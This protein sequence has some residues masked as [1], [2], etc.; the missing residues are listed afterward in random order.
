MPTIT[1]PE[2]CQEILEAL[3]TEVQE[4][5]QVIVH[6]C[7]P[8]TYHI[9]SLIRIW[10]STFLVDERLNHRSSL[11][12]HENISLF[13]DWTPVP[14]M[15]DYWFTLVFSGLPKDCKSFDLR[16]EIPEEGGFLVK[17]IKRNG[18]DVYRVKLS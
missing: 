15:Q 12:H 6:C 9:G 1:K 4:E 18:T 17:N 14:P 8:A 5:Q 10:Q 7:Y 3:L 11:L 16:E 13:P 2:I